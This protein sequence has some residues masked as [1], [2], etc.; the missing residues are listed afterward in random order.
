VAFRWPNKQHSEG[1]W[2][3]MMLALDRSLGKHTSELDHQGMLIR[4]GPRQ[5]YK[6]NH[7]FFNIFTVF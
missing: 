7:N 6:K 2:A 4:T 1:L 5:K 3:G